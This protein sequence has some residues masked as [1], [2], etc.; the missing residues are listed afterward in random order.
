[1]TSDWDVVAVAV[2]FF[3]GWACG[4]AN[5]WSAKRKRKRSCPRVRGKE[6]A[7][8]ESECPT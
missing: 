7:Y 4:A 6:E 5:S 2:G 1:M 8:K 3:T